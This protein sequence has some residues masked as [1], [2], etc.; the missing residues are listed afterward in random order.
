M[1]ISSYAQGVPSWVDLMTSDQDAA[2]A[3]YGAAFGWEAMISGPEMGNYAMCMKG[4]HAVAGIGGL[5]EGS[6]MPTM[7]T[8]YISV[9]DADVI[10]QRAA[11]AGGQIIAPVLAVAGEGSFPGRMAV[12][13]DPS[14]GVF[15]IWEAHDHKGSGLANEPG[16]FAWNELLSR[17]PASAR[18]FFTAVFDYDWEVMDTNTEMEYLGAKVDG[19]AIAGLMP[20]PGDVPAEV[21]SYWNLYFAVEDTDETVIRAVAAGGTALVPAF[22]SPF[23]RMAVLADPQ[24]ANFSI[25]QV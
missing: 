23:G 25:V 15:G 13:A 10:A 21:P 8:T 3:F 12:I 1:I 19:R 24:G 16:S 7:W 22:D 18:A 17:D 14:G 11:E 9:E 4:G 20:M 2:I 5:P 6:P